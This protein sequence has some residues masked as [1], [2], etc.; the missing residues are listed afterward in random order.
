MEQ[1]SQGN[2][3]EILGSILDLFAESPA[4]SRVATGLEIVWGRLVISSF[5]NEEPMGDPLPNGVVLGITEQN[6]LQ[7]TM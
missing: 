2:S 7:L 6:G 3:P 5:G 4:L 1:T